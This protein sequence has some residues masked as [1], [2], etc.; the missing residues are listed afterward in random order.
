[1]R[2]DLA[3]ACSEVMARASDTQLL[4]SVALAGRLS[5][6]TPAYSKVE[7][8]PVEI[9][10]ILHLQF[11]LTND[12][13]TTTKNLPV[14]DALQFLDEQLRA[15]YANFTVRT[16]RSLWQCRIT[17][18][19]VAL[20]HEEERDGFAARQHDRVKPR[21]MEPNDRFL[22]AVGISDEA[23]RV[24]PSKFD[25]YRQIDE[26]VRIF[27]TTVE[28]AIEHGQLEEPTQSAP[29]RIVDLGCGHAYLTFAVVSWI[30]HHRGWPVQVAGVD[31]RADSVKRNQELSEHL[32]VL[33]MNFLVGDIA[34]STAFE[35]LQV[36]VVLAL[37]ACDTATDDALAWA[38][39][40]KV[41]VVL[42]APCCHHD[43]QRQL[44]SAPQPYGLVARH[45]LLRE[46]FADVL[47]D[48]IRAALLRQQGYRVE[49]F[50]FVG[51]EHTPRNVMIRAVLTGAVPSADVDEEL[52]ALTSAWGIESALER[53]LG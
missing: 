5:N 45:D 53:R 36:S 8:R 11:A 35:G 16:T 18:R 42:A 47:T 46:R 33:G 23:G 30:H 41:P 39:R 31:R 7:L 9:R 13:G 24:K 34:D 6:R 17:K 15:G 48:G 28:R 22:I 4:V 43:V 27:A 20:V 52:S 3:T 12:T 32:G 29:L 51:G 49:V 14:D 37:H 10:S 44:Q 21:M 26:F 2:T 40:R 50:E 25:K 1:M 38:V 19:L